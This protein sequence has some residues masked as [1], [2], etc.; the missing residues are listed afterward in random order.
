MN[1][2]GISDNIILLEGGT[3]IEWCGCDLRTNYSV[4]LFIAE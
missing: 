3:Y 2:L 1:C 4:I